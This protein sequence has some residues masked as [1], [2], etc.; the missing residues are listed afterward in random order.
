MRRMVA[1]STIF[2]PTAILNLFENALNITYL[3][4][5]RQ[6]SP[7][8]VLIGFTAVLFTFWKTT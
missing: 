4:L 2:S 1:K 3:V 7:V 6:H 8:A 5:A